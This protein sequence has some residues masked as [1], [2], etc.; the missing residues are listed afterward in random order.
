MSEALKGIE[1]QPEWIQVYID[2]PEK[3]Q[4]LYRRTLL[5]VVISQI[6]GGQV[7]QLV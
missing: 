6:F 1:N 7:L 2:S 4:Q 3:Q 5:I